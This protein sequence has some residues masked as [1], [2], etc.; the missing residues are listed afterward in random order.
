MA[1]HRLLLSTIHRA[2][3]K[4]PADG[5]VLA[6]QIRAILSDMASQATR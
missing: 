6:R 4:R 1:V 3:L 5:S 2:P